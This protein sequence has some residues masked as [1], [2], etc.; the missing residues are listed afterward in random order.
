MATPL[1]PC[2]D[3][4][5]A[6][7]RLFGLPTNGCSMPENKS[8]KIS[9]LVPKRLI[10]ILRGPNSKNN[11]S[12]SRILLFQHFGARSQK[13]SVAALLGGSIGNKRAHHSS[14]V[15]FQVGDNVPHCRDEV[16]GGSIM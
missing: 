14:L 2:Q 4:P 13:S 7:N 11:T 6:R 12:R 8:V 10:S 3:D 15:G 1:L 16:K 5:P 9:D